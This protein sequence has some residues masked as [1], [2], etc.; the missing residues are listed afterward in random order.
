MALERRIPVFEDLSDEEADVYR[1]VQSAVDIRH[2]VERGP[3]GWTIVVCAADYD[4][5]LQAVEQYLH[6]NTRQDKPEE[7]RYE[8]SSAGIWAGF[9]LLIFY[10]V[11]GP[12]SS[13]VQSYAASADRILDGELYI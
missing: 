10:L 2:Q 3:R 13:R 12:D 11:I 4:E 9:L 6:E 8:R 1:M 7:Y 5:A